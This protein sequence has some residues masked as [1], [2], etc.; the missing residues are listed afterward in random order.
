MSAASHTPPPL[1]PYLT[2][3]DA[4][5]AID[6]YVRAFGAKELARQA[7]PDGSKLIHA[8]LALPNGGTFMLA[9]A[10]LP[11][12]QSPEMKGGVSSTPKSLGGSPVTLHLDLPDVKATWARAV[13]AGAQVK[14]PLALQFW[15]DEYGILEDP[16]GHRWSLATRAKVATKDELDAGAQKHFGGETK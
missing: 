16:F 14:M 12:G 7:T 9:D 13:E 2:V 1:S 8:A 10:L 15:G 5:A 3:H 6:F 11:E 4:K